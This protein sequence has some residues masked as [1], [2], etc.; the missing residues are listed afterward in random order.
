MSE[1]PVD[2]RIAAPAR[3]FGEFLYRRVDGGEF[4][5]DTFGPVGDEA[6]VH[7][8]TGALAFLVQS[9]DG[10]RRPRGAGAV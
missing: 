9:D 6:P 10:M 8:R 7:P 3:R 2:R 5:W 4:G 1:W